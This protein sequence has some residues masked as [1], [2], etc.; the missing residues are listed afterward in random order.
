[1]NSGGGKKVCIHH[2]ADPIISQQT[3]LL[4]NGSCY[5]PALQ[6]CGQFI[7]WDSK[8]EALPLILE[9]VRSRAFH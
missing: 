7:T 9:W 5:E 1:M 3:L 6:R 4:I 2:K 8:G